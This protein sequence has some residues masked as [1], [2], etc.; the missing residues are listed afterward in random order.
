MQ[1][2]I[3]KGKTGRRMFTSSMKHSC[4]ERQRNVLKSVFQGLLCDVL[5]LGVNTWF[6][7]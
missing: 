1:V 4:N 5:V 3:E 2:K 7:Y 6:L